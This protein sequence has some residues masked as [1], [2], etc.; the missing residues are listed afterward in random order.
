[1]LILLKNFEST[2]FWGK[3]GDIDFVLGN[4]L[5]YNICMVGY[6]GA[7]NTYGR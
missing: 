3:N 6:L 4:I 5:Y 1:M 2:R 7:Y